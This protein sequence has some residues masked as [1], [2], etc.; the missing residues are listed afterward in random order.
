MC[1]LWCYWFLRRFWPVSA[2]KLSIRAAAVS[3]ANLESESVE[4]RACFENSAYAQAYGDQDFRFP[5]HGRFGHAGKPPRLENEYIARCEE[6]DKRGAWLGVFECAAD[7]SCF[8]DCGSDSHSGT[9]HQHEGDPCPVHP[10][11]P[12]VG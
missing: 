1:T 2:I 9:W 8:M 3:A 7:C 5:L 12:T 6:F 11:A 4:D 10:N